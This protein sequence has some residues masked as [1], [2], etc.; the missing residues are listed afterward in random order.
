M[1]AE[2]INS[3]SQ[4]E[5]SRRDRSSPFDKF[6]AFLTPATKTWYGNL[7]IGAAVVTAAVPVAGMYA[8]FS[9]EV[10]FMDA[11]PH[12]YNMAS[13]SQMLHLAKTFGPAALQGDAA[14]LDAAFTALGDN[15][16][17]VLLLMAVKKATKYGIENL[18]GV[19]GQHKSDLS[20]GSPINVYIDALGRVDPNNVF[21]KPHTR[22]LNMGATFDLNVRVAI[23]DLRST[24]I[25]KMIS[26]N[27]I[28]EFH[29]G[30]LDLLHSLVFT[31]MMG[32][33]VPEIEKIY[34]HTLFQD[35]AFQS[36]FGN[37]D[38][39]SKSLESNITNFSDFSLSVY[40]SLSG[41]EKEV[42]T[43]DPKIHGNME[44]QQMLDDFNS[45]SVMAFK[46][47]YEEV[48]QRKVMENVLNNIHSEISILMDSYPDGQIDTDQLEHINNVLSIGS[49]SLRH[50]DQGH[51]KTV[52]APLYEALE[53][54]QSQVKNACAIT[55]SMG[56]ST[57]NIHN[58]VGLSSWIKA[59]N[60]NQNEN[61]LTQTLWENVIPSVNYDVNPHGLASKHLLKNI[62]LYV[63]QKELTGQTFERGDAVALE[64]GHRA[65]YDHLANMS[66]SPS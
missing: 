63:Q 52:Y 47:G 54:L 50:F 18:T 42:F 37:L 60:T 17:L 66:P 53:K 49:T 55:D 39:L 8:H 61:S 57:V 28:G 59:A 16:E 12:Y 10:S 30:E 14:A 31:K 23:S 2:T 27:K 56:H 33:H 19:N 21:D 44:Q 24:F 22:R 43:P 41:F 25:G 34:S 3:T 26:N 4:R 13:E 58:V 38:T 32:K 35:P 11:L 7:A 45:M 51:A 48:E 29:Q 36:I 64:I 1:A 15:A 65:V 46:M 6:S 9:G 5:Q 62:E 20:D 40:R